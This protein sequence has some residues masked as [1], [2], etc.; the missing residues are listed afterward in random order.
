[1]PAQVTT[2]RDPRHHAT[3]MKQRL[4]EVADDLRRDIGKADEVP[5]E[6]MLQ[7]SA[8]VLSGL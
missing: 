5:L 6:A 4:R 2:D 3:P 7:T 1:M 8:E